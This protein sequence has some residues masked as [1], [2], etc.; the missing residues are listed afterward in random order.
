M[1][2]AS[3]FNTLKDMPEFQKLPYTPETAQYSFYNEIEKINK[4]IAKP[5]VWS[6]SSAVGN[7]P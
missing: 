7:A 6:E 2:K 4:S 1:L 3:D 5:Q